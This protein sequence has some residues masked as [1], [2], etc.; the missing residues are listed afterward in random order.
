MSVHGA[1]HVVA[2]AISLSACI[3]RR[4]PDLRAQSGYT[5]HVFTL[6]LSPTFLRH[7]LL[8]SAQHLQ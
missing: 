8:R 3:K 4:T 2:N 1:D 6:N 5:S 7:A